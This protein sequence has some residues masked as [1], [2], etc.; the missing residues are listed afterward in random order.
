MYG[1]TLGFTSKCQ[2][3]AS[4]PRRARARTALVSRRDHLPWE[5]CKELSPKVHRLLVQKLVLKGNLTFF[6][7]TLGILIFI[8]AN[9][10]ILLW[11]LT[12]TIFP[13]CVLSLCHT[14]SHPGLWVKD[15]VN[16]LSSSR[17]SAAR[18]GKL[19]EG[20][21]DEAKVDPHRSPFPALGGPWMTTAPGIAHQLPLL[22]WQ[23][24]GHKNSP[25]KR[26]LDSDIKEEAIFPGPLCISP[27]LDNSIGQHPF[28]KHNTESKDWRKGSLWVAT[29]KEK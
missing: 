16:W 14:L 12:G 21:V 3:P 26:S 25:W 13:L 1:F 9:K 17:H 28:R 7:L 4:R 22:P 5:Q 10:F 29:M 8:S 20:F 23:R 27:P 2:L 19:E 15:P 6:R 11:R 24:K 18:P